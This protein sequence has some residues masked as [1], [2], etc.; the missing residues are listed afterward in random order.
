MTLEDLGVTI[1]V[2]PELDDLTVGGLICGVGVETS[3]HR[4]G[5][6]THSCIEYELVTADGELKRCSATENE[7]L[8]RAIP[9]SHGTLGFLVG[10]TMKIV[11]SKPWIKLDYEPYHDKAE[12]IAAFSEASYSDEYDFVE[13]LIYA[14]DKW[15]LMKGV[16]VDKPDETVGNVN[17]IGAYY[18][19]WFFKHVER[20]L[21]EPDIQLTEFVPL[22]DYYH[23]HTRS[24]FWEMQ[25]IVTFGNH[26]LFRYT[27]GW[28]MPPNVSMLK[29]CQTEEV[30][31]LYELFHVVQDM[32]VP[33]SALSDSVDVMERDFDVYPAWICPMRI[34]PEDAG[35]LKPTSSGEE[36]FVDVG[37]YGVPGSGSGNPGKTDYIAQ[38]SSR[39]VEDFVRSVEGYQMLYA[40][41]YQSKKEFREMF[42][43]SLLD[44][45][46]STSEAT[47][48]AFPEV[49]DKVNKKA[50]V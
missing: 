43:H 45:I 30:R 41:M 16:L 42:D 32:L 12:A 31:R 33:L 23:R 39:R 25:D 2:L 34:F 4:H 21:N 46:R 24:L 28:A 1:P 22:R 29:R 18:K 6:F 19:Q 13:S 38:P 10:V 17:K 7:E 3:S 27:L 40:D 48:R 44:K 36:M 11:E 14:N 9:W 37:I 20:F 50:R 15:V 49:F 26:W 8:F 47:M 5:L 35:F